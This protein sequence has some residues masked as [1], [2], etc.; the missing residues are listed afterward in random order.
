MIRIP[1]KTLVGNKG[2]TLKIR[3]RVATA[4]LGRFTYS[5]QFALRSIVVLSRDC[6]TEGLVLSAIY[7]F[8]QNKYLK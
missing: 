5:Q 8:L 2:G 6:V 1:N 4:R 3:L 7:K